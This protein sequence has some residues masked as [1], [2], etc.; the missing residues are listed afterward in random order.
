VPILGTVTGFAPTE[1][2]D[3]TLSGEEGF[4]YDY[5]PIKNPSATQ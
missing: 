4:I 1:M 5:T 2:G 3:A